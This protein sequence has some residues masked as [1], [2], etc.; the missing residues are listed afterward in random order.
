MSD[1][2]FYVDTVSGFLGVGP[3]NR[4]GPGLTASVY[5][6]LYLHAEVAHYRSENYRGLGHRRSL[7]YAIELAQTEADRLNAKE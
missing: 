5:D 6:R 7:E 3:G 4:R 1:E 2:R